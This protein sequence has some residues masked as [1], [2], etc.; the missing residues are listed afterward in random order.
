MKIKGKAP[1]GGRVPGALRPV[2]IRYAFAVKDRDDEVRT[3]LV[4]VDL[5]NGELDLA[6]AFTG[7]DDEQELLSE[8]LIERV[9]EALRSIRAAVKPEDLIER[10]D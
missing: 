4:S 10:D 5:L 1:R 3:F 6:V 8:A 9:V 2:E 7:R